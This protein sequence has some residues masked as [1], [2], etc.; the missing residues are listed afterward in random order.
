M[1]YKVIGDKMKN[2]KQFI[3]YKIGWEQIGN[4]ITELT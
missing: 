3:A 2:K 1:N 4:G